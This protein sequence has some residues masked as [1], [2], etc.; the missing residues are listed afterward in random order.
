MITSEL[1]PNCPLSGIPGRIRR[2]LTGQEIFSLYSSYHGIPLDKMHFC[3]PPELII[4]EYY[5]EESG[6]VWYHPRK[7]GNGAYYDHLSKTFPSYYN[8]GSWDKKECLKLICEQRPDWV[9][10]VGSGDGWLLDRFLANDIDAY[11]IEINEES[12]RNCRRRGLKVVAPN[13]PFHPPEG[14]GVLCLLQTL[15]HLD[16]PLMVM[17]EYVQ[18]F[19]PRYIHLS[20]PCFETLLGL[21]SDPLCWPPHHATSWSE[22]AMF[23]LGRKIGYECVS[24]TYSPITFTGFQL[25]QIKEPGAKFFLLPHIPGGLYG[26]IVFISKRIFG[27]SWSLRG[28]SIYTT[29][30]LQKH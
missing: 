16:D 14:V 15:E 6:L 17:Q 1:S 27:K 28:H 7:L 4:N 8:P 22:K 11:G 24:T 9:V 5:S 19:Q 12:I 10:E 23:N 2:S 26:R 18:K 25:Q 3:L 29:F 13:T 20:A 30:E 21:T